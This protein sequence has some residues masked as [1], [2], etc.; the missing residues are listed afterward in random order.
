VT[1]TPDAVAGGR[2]STREDIA[3][4][5]AAEADLDACTLIWKAAIDHYQGRLGQPPMP[6]DVA[7]L[8]RLLVHTLGTDPER[9]W[10]AEAGDVRAGPGGGERR[11]G[12][13]GGEGSAGSPAA[14]RVIGFASATLRDGLWFLAM[15]FVRPDLQGGGI[16]ARLMDLA[17]AAAPA[18]AVPGPDD[19]LDS[20]I[21][22]WGMCT[23]AAQPIS[24]GLYA[25]RGMLPRVPI[26]RLFGEIRRARALP[27]L[28]QSLEAVPFEAV[29][30]SRPEGHRRLADAVGRLDRQLIGAAHPVDH[31][32]LRREGR[33]G[34][35]LQERGRPDA[36]PLGY[37]YGSGGDDWGRSRLPIPRCTRRCS[38]SP[39]A[40]RRCSARS[41]S[42]C[43][44]LPTAPRGRS[45]TPASATTASRD[46]CA[47]RGP[48]TRSSATRRS[49]SRS[50]EAS[51]AG[52]DAGADASLR[53]T[54]LPRTC[55]RPE[56]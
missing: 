54:W 33:S 12:P 17:Q 52:H 11:A 42:G 45:S 37:V 40:G 49:R 24:N 32:Y 6:S 18:V 21:Q 14:P 39:Y 41:R 31:A 22:T 44:A 35:L 46:C 2:R 55:P 13:G 15:L 3:Y 56:S 29:V 4:R 10:V 36:P 47:G 43:P 19:P 7:P 38:G 9:F 30:G 28:P 16:G 50:S 26:W 25:R 27:E 8:R 34:F 53:G 20:G 23:D 48:T 51:P 1:T 5:P